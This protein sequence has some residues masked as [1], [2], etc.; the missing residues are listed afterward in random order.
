VAHTACGN[1]VIGEMLSDTPV[2]VAVCRNGIM[3]GVLH[4]VGPLAVRLRPPMCLT[5]CHRERGSRIWTFDDA[6]DSLKTLDWGC[7]LSDFT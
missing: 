6:I 5:R 3:D 1:D 2:S 7:Y 4:P